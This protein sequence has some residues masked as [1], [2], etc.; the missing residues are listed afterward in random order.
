MSLSA[1][2]AVMVGVLLGTD[3]VSSLALAGGQRKLCVCR[4]EA[5]SRNALCDRV[6][7]KILSLPL[8]SIALL[9]ELPSLFA[10]LMHCIAD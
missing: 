7:T 1:G 2:C 4:R 6:G 9:A 5:I 10:L 8:V 3:A